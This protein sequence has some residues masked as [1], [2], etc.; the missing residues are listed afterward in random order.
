ML[1]RFFKDRGR[2][3]EVAYNS[4]E[5]IIWRSEKHFISG[6]YKKERRKWR[7]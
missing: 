5:K 3:L 6:E 7:E 1:G 2:E 4:K